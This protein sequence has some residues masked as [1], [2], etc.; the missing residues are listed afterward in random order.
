MATTRPASARPMRRVFT[1]IFLFVTGGA[2]PDT[3]PPDG[4]ARERK[5]GRGGG[6]AGSRGW[7]ASTAE[8]TVVGTAAG[9]GSSVAASGTATPTQP[10][11]QHGTAETPGFGD[12]SW[13]C[14]DA[15]CGPAWPCAPTPPPEWPASVP[16]MAQPP[17][18]RCMDAANTG[19]A[20]ITS[21]TSKARMARSRS[22]LPSFSA[23]TERAA[24][25]PLSSRRWREPAGLSPQVPW[26]RR[27]LQVGAPDRR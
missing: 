12:W 22:G 25:A 17:H 3:A 11:R 5:A 20:E 6:S 1:M 27:P 10:A 19:D 14:P 18:S 26:R 23:R 7:P 4:Q 2:E 16:I 24:R 8:K 21:A 15:P 13:P 9:G